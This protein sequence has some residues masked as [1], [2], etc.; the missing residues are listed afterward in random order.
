MAALS[1]GLLI[2]SFVC[3]GSVLN[4]RYVLTAA[5]CVDA[6][7]N[8]GSLSSSLRITVGTNRWN[9]GGQSYAVSRNVT[10]QHYVPSIIKNDLGLL[11]TKTAMVLSESVKPISLNFKFIGAGVSA[12]ATGWGRTRRNGSL[13]PKLLELIV[14]TLDGEACVE[15][16]ARVAACLDIVAPNV[17]P[18]IE[19]CV[20]HSPGHGMCNGDSGSALVQ[21]ETKQQIGIVSWGFPCARGA[22][23]VFTRVSAYEDWLNQHVVYTHFCHYSASMKMVAKY[24]FL[25]AIL[26]VGG[27]ALPLDDDDMSIFFDHTVTD[28]EGRIV[29]GTQA[30]DGGVPWMVGLSNGAVV[31]GFL[32]G[33]S[34]ISNRHILTAAHCIRAVVSGNTLSNS[35]RAHVGTNRWNSGGQTLAFQRH[36]MHPN[37]V[38][39]TIKN[40]VGVLTTSANINFN[41]RVARVVLSWDW[42]GGNIPSMVTGWGRTST[43]GSLA[44]N[45]MELRVNTF[46]ANRCGAEVARVANQ[47]NIRAPHVDPQIE[48]CTF[49]AVNRGTCNGDS[50]SA[51]VR[52]SNNRQI[53]VVSWGLPCARGAPDMYA[54]VSAFRSFIEN[55]MR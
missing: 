45:L 36:V 31:R 2:R 34:I 43:G 24:G 16:V 53:G 9:R 1:N 44:P 13:S 39:A 15:E 55:A 26:L 50:G 18:H 4:N 33:G 14:E 23:D 27:S 41:A 8:S 20:Y 25:L 54:R 46:D 28:A 49:L 38:H 6:L 47:I 37:Y 48:I 21:V 5:H 22:P 51:L 32:C 12:R 17:E 7:F 19:L 29:G 35:L 10:H 30:R 42:T 52:V 40:D 11:V 3:G